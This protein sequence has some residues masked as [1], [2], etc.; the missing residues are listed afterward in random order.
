MYVQENVKVIG[1][2]N[3]LPGRLAGRLLPNGSQEELRLSLIGA[4][5]P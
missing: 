4:E 5:L 3:D 1:T 2:G